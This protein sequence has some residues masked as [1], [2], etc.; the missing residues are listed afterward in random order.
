MNAM[1][2]VVAMPVWMNAVYAMVITA[3]VQTAVAYPMVQVIHVTG[4]VVH[5]MMKLMMAPVTVRAM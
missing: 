4:N 2:V 1:Y 3:P 5:V